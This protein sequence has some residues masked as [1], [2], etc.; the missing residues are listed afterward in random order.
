[1]HGSKNAFLLQSFKGRMLLCKKKKIVRSTMRA[2]RNCI[3][4]MD[5]CSSNV[6]NVFLLSVHFAGAKIYFCKAKCSAQPHILWPD[7]LRCQKTFLHCRAQHQI[8]FCKATAAGQ[9]FLRSLL[10]FVHKM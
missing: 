6:T 5:F 4:K 9:H 7:A 1:M 10:N 3:A 8:H 2:K